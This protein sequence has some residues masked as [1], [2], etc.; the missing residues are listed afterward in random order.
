MAHHAACKAV[1]GPRWIEYKRRGVGRHHIHLVF[2]EEHRPVF[3]FFNHDELG[4]HGPHGVAR[5]DKIFVVGQEFGL[6]VVE[7]QAV[8]PLEQR[9][10]LVSLD[11]D[12]EIHRVG[13]REFGTLCLIQHAELYGGRGVAKK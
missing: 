9:P 3:P 12:P 11:I 8:D 1:A 10:K 4:P 13:H 2:A 5:A 6:R 7:H